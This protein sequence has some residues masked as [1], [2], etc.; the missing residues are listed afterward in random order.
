MSS[1]S[2]L[3]PNCSNAITVTETNSD[4]VHDTEPDSDQSYEAISQERNSEQQVASSP[5][6]KRKTDFIDLSLSKNTDELLLP[7]FYYSNI[8]KG[9]YCKICSS[10]AQS[11]SGPTSFVNKVSDFG[12]HPNRTAS[13]NLSFSRHQ[14]GIKNKQAFKELS[15]RRTKAF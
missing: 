15:L 4:Q 11:I 2:S 9:W 8:E 1:A 3:E 12:D 10:F 14:N 7:D 6:K 13:R 5:T